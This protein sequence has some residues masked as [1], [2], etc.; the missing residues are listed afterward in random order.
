MKFSIGDRKEF[1]Q[2]KVPLGYIYIYIKQVIF[3]NGNDK[4]LIYGIIYI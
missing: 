1:E 3:F 2:I 4:I